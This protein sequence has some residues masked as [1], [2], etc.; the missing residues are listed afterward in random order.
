MRDPR[1]AVCRPRDMFMADCRNPP[2][3]WWYNLGVTSPWGLPVL[4][5]QPHV[6]PGGLLQSFLG[7]LV[8]DEAAARANMGDPSEARHGR[9]M[10]ERLW[11]RRRQVAV[12]GN[13]LHREGSARQCMQGSAR[14]RQRKALAPAWF[15]TGVVSHAPRDA[16]PSKRSLF[17]QRNPKDTVGIVDNTGGR[18]SLTPLE[19]ALLRRLGQL[20]HSR[21]LFAIFAAGDEIHFAGEIYIT[22]QAAHA[23]DEQPQASGGGSGAAIDIRR[24]QGA[25]A[26]CRKSLAASE[27]SGA[28]G[29][30]APDL[31]K[32]RAGLD[33]LRELG[34]GLRAELVAI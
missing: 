4:E 11:I 21:H 25:G 17:T 30:Y 31:T 33:H 29:L 2:W 15:C 19:R 28:R 34:P 27:E 5:C 3:E 9:S 22:L 7:L 14:Q 26:P 23:F 32:A 24:G 8:E 6:W 16:W 1:G 13:A 20:E 18:S 12:Q 10:L